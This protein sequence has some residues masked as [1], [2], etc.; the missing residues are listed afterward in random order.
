MTSDQATDLPVMETAA[1]PAKVWRQGFVADL[2]RHR[3]GVF[4][5]AVMGLFIV[6]AVFG[7]L[8]VPHDP[9]VGELAST[10]SGPTWQHLF[11]T[12]ELGHRERGTLLAA[13][14]ADRR[15]QLVVVVQHVQLDVRARSCPALHRRGID[16]RVVPSLE[17][18]NRH[19][20][21]DV[22]S[23]NLFHPSPLQF[24][25]RIGTSAYWHRSSST[26]G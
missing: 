26:S 6:L 22:L 9:N 18:L 10:L 5:V 12:D 25:D 17:D 14:A 13:D 4:G 7:R 1:A 19:R 15:L 16:D 24:A 3:G 23:R 8:V 11:G 2:L 20:Q 21:I